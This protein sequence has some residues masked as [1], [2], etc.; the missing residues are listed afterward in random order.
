VLIFFIFYQ[1]AIKQ[2]ERSHVPIMA[3]VRNNQQIIADSILCLEGAL[4]V[5]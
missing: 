2:V 1:S 4:L 5:G 3:S